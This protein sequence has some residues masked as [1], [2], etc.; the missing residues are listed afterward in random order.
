[1]AR[2]LTDDY[3]HETRRI[4][5]KRARQAIRREARLLDEDNV[6]PI[7][8]MR[9]AISRALLALR[10]FDKAIIPS[11]ARKI[12]SGLKQYRDCLASVRDLD[13]MLERLRGMGES[14]LPQQNAG[15]EQV[16]ETIESE[17]SEAFADLRDV[18][19]SR[20]RRSLI[21]Q[22]KAM[23]SELDAQ[24]VPRLLSG[25]PRGSRLGPQVARLLKRLYR[26]LEKRRAAMADNFAPEPMHAMRIAAKQFRYAINFFRKHRPEAYRPI[27]DVLEQ[28]HECAGSLHDIAVLTAK[29]EARHAKLFAQGEAESVKQAD[30]GVKWLLM[31]LEEDRQ[32]LMD[33][34][35]LIWSHLASDEFKALVKEALR[36]A[37][38]ET[39]EQ[40]LCE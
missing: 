35:Y 18:M 30:P 26:R 11:A 23:V 34:F 16:I 4:L 13:V 28:L 6:E 32:S 9:V 19:A 12:T 38:A 37:P 22:L 20:R 1:V 25:M 40:E 14:F 3:R 5:A 24:P 8:Q 29:I 15:F 10:L 2:V 33:E 7:H 17:R 21:T 39:S 27:V 31:R 36:P